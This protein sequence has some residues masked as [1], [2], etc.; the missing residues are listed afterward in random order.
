M[1]KEYKSKYRADDEITPA[2]YLAEFICERIAK[3][4]KTSLFSKFWNDPKWKKVFVA[5]IIHAN[6]LLKDFTCL[7]IIN[8][9]N[10]YR[11]KRIFSLGLQKPIREIIV[12]QK[13]NKPKNIKPIEIKDDTFVFDDEENANNVEVKKTKSVWEKLS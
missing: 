11:G 10:S 1:E 7:E 5:Q 13:N 2:Q 12:E 3:K 4:D 6:K 8:A 9:L